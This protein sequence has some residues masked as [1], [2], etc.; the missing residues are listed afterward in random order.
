[1]TTLFVMEIDGKKFVWWAPRIA[2]EGPVGDGAM[3]LPKGEPFQ[4]IPWDELTQGMTID[5]P[6]E[7]S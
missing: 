2:S 7:E 6:D 3:E 4:G 5:V 1:M